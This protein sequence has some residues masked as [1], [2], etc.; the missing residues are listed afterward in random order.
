[1]V[2][3]CVVR[4]FSTGT[5]TS[6]PR[7]GTGRDR[8]RAVFE[9]EGGSDVLVEVT[10]GGGDVARQAEPGKRGQREVRGPAETGL[11]HAAAPHG[12]VL[13]HAHIVDGACL[14]VTPDA[15]RLDVHDRARA[16]GDGRGGGLC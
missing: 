7:P 5:R 3:D 11:Q 10:V 1:M 2:S 14:E 16:E 12:D 6:T 15:S 13:R 8:D 9:H 4:P